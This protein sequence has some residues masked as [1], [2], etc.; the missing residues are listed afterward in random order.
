MLAAFAGGSVFTA[1]KVTIASSN[2]STLVDWLDETHALAQATNRV[3]TPVPDAAFRGFPS[4][5]FTA[6]NQNYDSSRAAATWN[7]LHDG[8]GGG[9][10]AVMVVEAMS[11]PGRAWYVI[12]TGGATAARGAS[13]YPFVDAGPVTKTRQIIRNDAANILSL[14]SPVGAWVEGTAFVIRAGYTEGA[15]PEATLDQNGV[16]Q[17]TGNTTGA[18]S[19]SDATRTL[20]LNGSMTAGDIYRLAA[21]VIPPAAW[22]AA[23]IAALNRWVKTLGIAGG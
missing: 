9:W 23:Q 1:S 11:A 21:L 3:P 6:S 7:R 19:A 22:T 16:S 13:G 14:T 20:R 12:D 18:P 15:S 8:S 2:T 5:R 4:L 17:A 10:A